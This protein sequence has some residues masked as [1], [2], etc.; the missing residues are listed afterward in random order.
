MSFRFRSFNKETIII[1]LVF[2]SEER[3]DLLQGTGVDEAVTKDLTNIE[4]EFKDVVLPFVTKHKDK[5]RSGYTIDY[6]II[7][8]LEA[9]F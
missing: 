6:N 3:K 7:F 1:V 5:F 9:R 8:I 2:Y 4:K